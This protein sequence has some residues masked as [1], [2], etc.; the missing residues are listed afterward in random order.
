MN[1]DNVF[2]D[3]IIDDLTQNRDDPEYRID[4]VDCL[5]K[6]CEMSIE[7]LKKDEM[8][9]K[10]N[11]PF[12][13]CGDI[14]GQFI[15]LMK[16]LE[17]GG[18]PSKNSYLFMGDYVDRGCNSVC[19]LT[20]LLALKCRYPKNIFLLR[21]NHETR[22][23]SQ[24]YGFFEECL[25]F[26]NQELWYRF[27]DV[28]CYLPI[29]AVI[30]ER[31]FCVH[32]GLSKDMTSLDMIKDL[33]RP[34]EIPEEGFITD[35]LWADPMPGIEGYVGSDRGTSFTFGANVAR[36]F[37]AHYDFDII[38]RA[39]QVVNNGYE[40]PFFPDKSVVTVFSAPNYCNEFGNKGAMLS[41]N[42]KLECSFQIVDPPEDAESDEECRP[43]TPMC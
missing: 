25:Q 13:V 36:D 43:D 8:L 5:L 38:C 37:L 31:I 19:T 10:I 32:G 12:N 39:H 14:H 15:D 27:N 41:I 30:S 23:I 24:L 7:T 21:G 2:L 35:L 26:Y 1:D 6:L 4:D 3:I 33:Q 34:L 9:L 17:L 18:D 28:F 40:F 42:E 29:A 22:D 11:A 16:F 20:M